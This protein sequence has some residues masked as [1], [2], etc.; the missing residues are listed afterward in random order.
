MKIETTINSKKWILERIDDA[1]TAHGVSRSRIVSLLLRKMFN[2]TITD[3]NR[4]S[5]VQYQK[6]DKLA[7][8]K[9][10]HIMLDYDLYEKCIDMRKLL[11][12]S[13]SKIVF[14]AFTVYFDSV[15]NELLHGED[16]DMC[17]RQYICIGKR[18]GDVF[19]YTVFWDFPPEEILK[20]IL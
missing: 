19:S 7:V 20:S 18:F 15:I 6:R 14:A 1:A 13:V 17:L 10:P 16:D 2:E 4:F 11:K 12:M 8:W 3:K 5:R 9:R